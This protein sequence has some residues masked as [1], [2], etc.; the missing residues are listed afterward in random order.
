MNQFL[1]IP[2]TD[3]IVE[4]V[5]LNTRLY[6][7]CLTGVDDNSIRRRITG[8]TNSLHFLA[9]HLADARY[10]ISSMIGIAVPSPFP[11]LELVRTIDEMPQP[12]P[13]LARILK[14]WHEIS[15]TLPD[16]LRA[17]DHSDLTKEPPIAFPTTSP[18]LLGGLTFLMQHES[19]HIGQMALLRKA[20]G[21]SAMSYD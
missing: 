4:I 20:L 15:K 21:F 9:C 3:P 1:D 7:N 19:Y 10:F 11:E 5:E 17:L 2:P 12:G 13:S 16:C 14:A 18:T 8:N 6:L